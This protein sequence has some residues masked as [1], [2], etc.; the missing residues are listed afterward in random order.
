MPYPVNITRYA[1]DKQCEPHRTGLLCGMCETNYSRTLGNGKCAECSNT[2]LLL[3]LPL[4]VSGLLLVALLFALNLTVTEG[5]INGL[6]FYANVI[7]V[8]KTVLFSK[9]KS[10]LY[11]FLAWMNLDLG[12]NTCFFDGMD[13]F[14]ETWLQFVYPL[15]LWA[16]ILVIIQVYSK[17]PI[18]A[19]KLVARM[20]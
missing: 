10:P 12:I 14:T 5:S 15:Y 1:V 18:L 2:Y 7:G 8:N 13:G 3:L 9:A 17:F 20:L 4:S 11:T 16:I 6:I 19:S